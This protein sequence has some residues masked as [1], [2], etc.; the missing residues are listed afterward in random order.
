M[1]TYQKLI[2]LGLVFLL[3]CSK[4]K[5]QPVIKSGTYELDV[6]RIESTEGPTPTVGTLIISHN[7]VAVFP[8]DLS[9]KNRVLTVMGSETIYEAQDKVTCEGTGR[10]ELDATHQIVRNINAVKVPAQKDVATI[11]SLRIEMPYQATQDPYKRIPGNVCVGFHIKDKGWVWHFTAIPS[12][13]D[14]VA[15]KGVT[16]VEVKESNV[17]AIGI[18]FETTTNVDKIS[19]QIQ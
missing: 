11:T 14:Q 6:S 4:D 12:N 15:Q 13:L 3:S 18:L 16:T 8:V 7:A 2:S 19:Y 10:T 17:D 1:K 9:A 5:S